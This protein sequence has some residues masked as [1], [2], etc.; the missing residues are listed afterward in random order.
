MLYDT[1]TDFLGCNKYASEVSKQFCRNPVGAQSAS[2]P[3]TPFN[4]SNGYFTAAQACCVCGGG[5]RYSLGLR[6]PSR[7]TVCVWGHERETFGNSFQP[8]VAAPTTF[9]FVSKKGFSRVKA[10][11]DRQLSC[12]QWLPVPIHNS[13]HFPHRGAGAGAP[14]HARRGCPHS[15]SIC[16]SMRV[17]LPVLHGSVPLL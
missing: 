12:A 9:G 8:K 17:W 10:Q 13:S 1:T 15:Q 16:H 7:K 3:T 14:I 11:C 2:P 4:Q 6:C 5:H